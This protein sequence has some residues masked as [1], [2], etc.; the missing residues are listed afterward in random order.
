V[1]RDEPWIANMP[2][3]PM[4]GA[5]EALPEVLDRIEQR[6]KALELIAD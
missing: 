6:R 2:G 4:A 1:F 3:D 5:A